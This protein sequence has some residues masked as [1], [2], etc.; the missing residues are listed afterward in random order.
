MALTKQYSLPISELDV[1]QLTIDIPQHN[2][3]SSDRGTVV[4]VYGDSE[5][6]EVEFV[7][8][9]GY[10]R[11]LLTLTPKQ[12]RPVPKSRKRLTDSQFTTIV[13]SDQG[14]F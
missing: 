13:S 5:A 1:V 3:R 9:D 7:D 12:I 14:L 2:L 8:A 10:T 4:A 6:Y 11:A